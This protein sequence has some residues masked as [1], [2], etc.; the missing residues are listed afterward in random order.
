MRRGAS[1]KPRSSVT[2]RKRSS[3]G[4]GRSGFTWS[5]VTGETPPQSSMPASSSTPKSSD[6][7]G[8]ACK[9]IDAGRI[10]RATAIDHR[11]SSSGQGFALCI[12]VPAFGKKFCTMTSCTLPYLA[13]AAARSARASMRSRRS[14]PMPTKM[15]DVNGMAS[16]PD[17]HRV[18]IRR[19]GSLS[20]APR[21][22]SKSSR[23]DSSIIPCDGDTRRNIASSSSYNAPALACG[24]SPVSVRTNCAMSCK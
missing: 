11:Y 7:F 12:A 3:A 16:S 13:C 2:S 10:N 18:S 4:H 14:S 23:N 5:A 17:M 1:A 15:P 9:W 22:H 19:C 24:R 6:K 21:W 8:G 20:G